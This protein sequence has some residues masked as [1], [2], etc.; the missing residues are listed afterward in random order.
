MTRFLASATAVLLVGVLIMIIVAVMV[1]PGGDRSLLDLSPQA[2]AAYL[3]R[4]QLE[5][6]EEMARIEARREANGRLVILLGVLGLPL[7]VGVVWA[8]AG[9]GQQRVTVQLPPY[10]RPEQIEA[11]WQEQ[12]RAMAVRGFLVDSE[13]R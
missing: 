2:A 6:T 1:S 7:V 4:L 12:D 8:L 10:V 11:Y 5:H 3:D 9:R 13:R